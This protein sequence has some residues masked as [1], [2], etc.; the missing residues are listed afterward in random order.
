MPVDWNNLVRIWQG[1]KTSHQR[2][3]IA[4]GI[5]ASFG[6]LAALM[7]G[8]V[9]D[10]MEVAH[11][12]QWRE[13]LF[14]LLCSAASYLMIG[15]SL[16]EILSLLGHQISFLGVIGIAFV[17]TTANYFVS[18]AGVSGFALKAH[19]L[20]ERGVPYGATVTASV[21]STALIYFVLG[22]IIAQGTVYMGLRMRGTMIPI[23]E[24]IMGLSVL[25]VT[26]LPFL[27]FFLNRRL[28]GRVTRKIFHWINRVV[29]YFSKKEIPREDFR[30]FEGQL[31]EGLEKV[32]SEHGKL[33]RAIAYTCLDWGLTMMSLYFCFRAVGLSLSAGH[34][35]TGFAVGQAATLIPVLPGGLG[36][37]EGSMAGVYQRLGIPF[38]DA[39]VAVLIY[40]MVYYIIPGLASIFLLWGLKVSEPALIEKTIEDT[41][42]E[43]LK[44]ISEDLE[45]RRI[46][47][48]RKKKR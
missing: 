7:L 22:I 45:R 33:T 47:K 16:W 20:R 35:S 15:F 13:V 44:V 30:R 25:A 10:I 3:A 40:R 34:L 21:L 32:R 26:S 23:L 41:L 12:I 19:L 39:M 18:S 17:S 48:E 24:G 5:L 9:S 31:N 4:L 11:R 6:I 29:Y 28:R 46:K 43:E 2:F 8:H 27:M 38:Q 37:M 36:A 1:R 14:A 42:P